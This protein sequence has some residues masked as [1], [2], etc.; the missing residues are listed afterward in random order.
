MLEAEI[1]IP[2]M[3]IMLPLVLV[4]S[5]IKMKHAQRRREW[6][7]AE[8]MRAMELGLPP[9]SGPGYQFWPSVAAIAIGAG[10][11]IVT[12]IFAWLATVSSPI[13]QGAY[14]AA[15]TVGSIAVISGTILASHLSG[16]C[17]KKAKSEKATSFAKPLQ[18]DPDAYDTVSQ[19][20]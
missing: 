9:T 16:G 4:P 2:V 20:G 12:F 1:V 5:I 10:V 8:R 11:P 14:A 7:H 15:G 18:Y 19:R 13:G 6:E 3:G 17:S